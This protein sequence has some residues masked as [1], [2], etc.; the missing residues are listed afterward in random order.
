MGSP[1]EFTIIVMLVVIG[2]VLWN[3]WDRIGQIQRDLEALKR[4]AGAIEP[5]SEGP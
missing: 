3:L 1:A 2:V 5:P 4:R